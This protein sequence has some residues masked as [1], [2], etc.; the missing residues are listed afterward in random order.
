MSLTERVSTTWSHHIIPLRLPLI[1][2][3]NQ[4]VRHTTDTTT[5]PALLFVNGWQ[6]AVVMQMSDNISKCIFDTYELL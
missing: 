1:S 2:Y 3:I 6:W 5:T 4:H